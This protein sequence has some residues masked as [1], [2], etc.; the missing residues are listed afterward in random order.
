MRRLVLWACG[1]IFVLSAAGWV[2]TRFYQV[3]LFPSRHTGFQLIRGSVEFWFNSALQG[4]GPS[5][6]A[7]APALQLP[8]DWFPS[9][10]FGI[11]PTAFVI[12]VPLWLTAFL[13]ATVALMV[14][15]PWRLRI[16]EGCCPSCNYDRAGLAA[17]A[18]CPECGTV[19]TK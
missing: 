9:V 11:N 10:G 12:D 14:W 8:W 5:D 16:G 13:S 4:P 2:F 15:R 17:D 3:L 6:Q 18:K 19:P 7:L 1:L